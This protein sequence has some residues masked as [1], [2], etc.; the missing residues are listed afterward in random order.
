MVENVP[1]R[2][3]P[4][5]VT[6]VMITTAIKAAIRPYSIAVAPSTLVKKRAKRL[7][8]ALSCR[9]ETAETSASNLN[10]A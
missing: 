6:A 10:A 9:S 5:V 4:V 1:D 2:L 7:N 3:V 8:E